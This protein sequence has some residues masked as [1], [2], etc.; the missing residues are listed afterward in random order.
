MTETDEKLY[1][2]ISNSVMEHGLGI[3][4]PLDVVG[5]ANIHVVRYTNRV[6]V[7]LF[8]PSKKSEFE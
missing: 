1:E 5:E 6:K 3:M 7:E 8:I 2:A 4:P